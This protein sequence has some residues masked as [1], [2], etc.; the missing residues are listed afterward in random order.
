[1]VSG[2][3]NAVSV[4]KPCSMNHGRQANT[5][6]KIKETWSDICPTLG[7][8]QTVVWDVVNIIIG[9]LGE[10]LIWRLSRGKI[11]NLENFCTIWK[12]PLENTLLAVPV[13]P[14]KLDSNDKDCKG[15]T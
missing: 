15:N 7:Q 13:V 2:Q 11:V 1:M 3:C 9:V 12:R 4:C 8:F 14:T 5:D 10:M 6:M